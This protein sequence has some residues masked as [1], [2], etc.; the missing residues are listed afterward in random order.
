MNKKRSQSSFL[1]KLWALKL[2]RVYLRRAHRAVKTLITGLFAYFLCARQK[3]W[4]DLNF[5]RKIWRMPMTFRFVVACNRA[6][7]LKNGGYWEMFGPFNGGDAGCFY[8]SS[9]CDDRRWL[10]LDIFCDRR[11]DK[12][13]TH[14]H[15]IPERYVA[16]HCIP[17]ACPVLNDSFEA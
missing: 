17:A 3:H 5:L 11:N 9:N 13:T 16:S 10:L 1:I 15:P 8:G 2:K 14:R 12:I 4:F 7:K 6:E